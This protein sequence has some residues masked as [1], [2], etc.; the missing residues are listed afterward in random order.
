M[1]ATFHGSSI[2]DRRTPAVAAIVLNWNRVDMTCR[3][4]ESLL[5]MP[6]VALSVVVVDNGSTGDDVR[7]LLERVPAARTI[8]LPENVGFSRAVNIGAVAAMRD[9]AEYVLLFNNDA[10]VE[11]GANVLGA[12][13]TELESDLT[14]GAAGAV[15][16]NDDES[17]SLQSTSYRFSMWY[18]V[19]RPQKNLPR[20]RAALPA[21]GYLSGSCQLV[22]ARA[23]AEIG[24]F[25]PDFFF[26]GD[27]VD[28]SRRLN[29]R[30]YRTIALDTPGVRHARGASIRIGSPAYVYTA[31]RSNLILIGKHARWYHY[32]TAVATSILATGALCA[33]GIRHGYPASI[34]AAFRAWRDFATR[35]W[36][37]FDGSRLDPVTRPT[38]ADMTVA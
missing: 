14:L 26:Y 27:D 13:L 2:V 30:G 28:F 20:G 19:P 17:S 8:E 10:Y 4:I 12:L 25:D 24:G 31:L 3:A 29:A 7:R 33:L 1:T 9:G 35:R 21:N 15:I 22:R 6:D 38:I 37:G 32:P 18:P 5:A 23:F 16:A 11:A 36:G 34:S